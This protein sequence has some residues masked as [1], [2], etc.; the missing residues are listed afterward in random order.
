MSMPVSVRVMS[1][2]A[3]P[4]FGQDADEQF[5]QRCDQRD[6]SRMQHVAL[7]HV[8]DEMRAAFLEADHDRVA[9]DAAGQHGAAAGA[10]RDGDER[11]DVDI[12]DAALGQGLHDLIALPF[13]IGGCFDVLQHAA[14]ADAEMLARRRSRAWGRATRTSTSLAAIALAIPRARGRRAR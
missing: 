11:R 2:S 3:R 8:D 9:H 1:I 5:A 4:L 14:A 12:G 7:G 13:A 6:S 10:R